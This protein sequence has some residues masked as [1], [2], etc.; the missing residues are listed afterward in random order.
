MI[1]ESLINLDASHQINVQRYGTKLSNSV[2][3]FLEDAKN[4]VLHKLENEGATIRNKSRYTALLSSI[5]KTLNKYYSSAT[6]D[7]NS[8][9]SDFI[10]S[11][12]SFVDK[13]FNSILVDHD[14]ILPSQ[15]QVFKAATSNPMQ[16]QSGA[17]D[18]KTALA[19]WKATEIKRANN[20]ITLGFF[21][22][23]TSAQ[24]AKQVKDSING[25]TKRNA[26]SIVRTSVNH[27]SNQTRQTYY[28]ENSDIVI[29]YK[30]IATLD[31]HTT[32]F[33]RD[34][35]GR[36]V[37]KDDSYQPM[38]PFHFGCR[39]STTPLLNSKFDYLKSGATRSSKDGYVASTTTYYDWLKTQSAS[40]QN[41]VLGK[42]KGLIFRNSGVTTEEFK[43]MITNRFGKELTIE[44]LAAKDT[45]IMEYLK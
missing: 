22:G 45:R 36:N 43:S 37:L 6:V 12:I 20:F 39:T 24:I 18:L 41:E 31:T 9:L 16:L 4:D 21:Q 8:G 5:N 33:C 32:P 10:D 23:Q 17:V 15:E 28:K 29:G 14:T 3:P 42:T 38:P 2:I 35:D 26:M 27:L 44:Q 13:S 7:I 25:I 11:E 30:V 19:S 40:V 34:I 1:S